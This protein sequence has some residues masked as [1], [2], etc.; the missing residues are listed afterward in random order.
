MD[1][2]A[3]AARAEPDAAKRYADYNHIGQ[4][5]ME[6]VPEIPIYYYGYARVVS[7]Q[8]INFAYDEMGGAALRRDGRRSI[9]ASPVS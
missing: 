4:M 1:A 9:A 5:I 2:A 6:D 3:E 7:P 8:I